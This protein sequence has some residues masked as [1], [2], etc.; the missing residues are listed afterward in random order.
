L[1]IFCGWWSKESN[2]FWF[3]GA[4][5]D[6][7]IAPFDL[8]DR[9]LTL[10]DGI[11]DTSLARNGRTFRRKAHLDRLADAAKMLAIPYDANAAAEALDR[12]AGAIRDG[13]VR[14]TLTRGGGARGLALPK[15]PKPVLFGAAAPQKETTAF[16][17]LTLA[18]TTIRRNETSPAARLKALPYLDAILG[19]E[20]AKAKGADEVLF[21]NTRGC[22]AC[23]ASANIFVVL[24]REIVTP[25]LAD[26]VLAGTV[27]AFVLAKARN[28]GFEATERSLSLDD[29]LQ[30]EALFATSSLRLIAR[31]RSL[32]AA[33]FASAENDVVKKL[34]ATVREAIV[35]ECGRI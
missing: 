31:C 6:K 30:A 23:L 20:E 2:V 17:I 15:D 24:G 18:T 28:L 26:G 12:L 27:R 35:I 33:V 14:L 1:A 5:H 10:G 9:G 16:P 34:Q 8:S 21:E 32:D 4:L 22:I 29:V 11:F 13:A 7:P 25:P 19:L 3:D